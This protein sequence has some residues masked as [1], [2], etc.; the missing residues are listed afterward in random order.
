LEERVGKRLMERGRFGARLTRD[1]QSLLEHASSVLEALEAARRVV[2]DGGEAAHETVMVGA[3][4]T[5][6]PD[7]LP[8]ALGSFRD[9]WPQARADVQI[10]V[11]ATLL[12]KLRAG[13]VAFVL[14]RMA[15]PAPV[16]GLT[17]EL[18][19][20]EALVVAARPGRA[21]MTEGEPGM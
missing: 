19:Y 9:A 7:L 8:E 15:G 17:V 18:V 16:A 21:L 20:A 14:R 10:G 6:A 1:G 13:A 3:L 4:P 2:Q 5:V 12:D 11:N